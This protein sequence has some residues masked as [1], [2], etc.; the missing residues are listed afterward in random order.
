MQSI[1]EKLKQI[2]SDEEEKTIEYIR[3]YLGKN[4]KVLDISNKYLIREAFDYFVAALLNHFT[5][6][7]TH[8]SLI[9]ENC[10]L[11]SKLLIKLMNSLNNLKIRHNVTTFDIANNQIELTEKLAEKISKFFE[12]SFSPKQITL[13]LQGN[14]ISSAAVIDKLVSLKRDFK[15]LSLYDTRLS[16]EALLSLSEILAKNKVILKLDLSYNPTAFTSSEV[17]HTFGISIGIN[18]HIESLN[19]SGN[20]SLQKDLVFI[21]FLSG[22]SNNKSLQELTI[23]NLNIKD[24][25][26]KIIGKILFPQ[27]PLMVLDLQSN[28]LTSK[29]IEILLNSL[30]CFITSLDVSYNDFRSN[31]VL[32]TFG[33][34]FKTTRTLRKLNISYSVELNRL[35]LSSLDVFC[36]GITENMSLGELWCEGMK[37]GDDPD[38]FCAKVGEAISNRKH[39]LTFKISAVNCFTGSQNSTII[40]HKSSKHDFKFA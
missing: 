36:K 21:K 9:L 1:Q 28:C 7:N 40:S 20:S 18:Q 3:S 8:K 39:S 19:L 24:R 5:T 22:L 13:I 37:I 14:L 15:E 4:S 2:Q 27:M 25:S 12:N 32:E 35:N 23:G 31:S 34:Y 30:S 6:Y 33:R 26:V 17:V 29:G 16:S 10:L 38:E 11:N